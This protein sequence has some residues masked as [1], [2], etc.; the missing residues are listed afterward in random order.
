MTEHIVSGRCRKFS[1][2]GSNGAWPVHLNIALAATRENG[3]SITGSNSA[4]RRRSKSQSGLSRCATQSPGG[5]D[6]VGGVRRRRLGGGGGGGGVMEPRLL[7]LKPFF[8]KPVYGVKLYAGSCAESRR[9]RGLGR[10]RERCST[11]VEGAT[12]IVV[13][14][15]KLLSPSSP[16]LWST[17]SCA[18]RSALELSKHDIFVLWGNVG[19]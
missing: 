4:S 8:A 18:I 5:D 11:G 6:G 9:A 10:Y 16:P 1:L 3:Y 17:I 13:D 14:P 12:T 2:P 19:D 7:Q 15:V